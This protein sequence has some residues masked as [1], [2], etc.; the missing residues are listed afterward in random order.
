ME[1][2]SRKH[3]LLTRGLECV[4][5]DGETVQ[6]TK[7]GAISEWGNEFES[8]ACSGPPEGRACCELGLA[9]RKVKP[10]NRLEALDMMDAYFNCRCACAAFAAAAACVALSVLVSCLTPVVALFAANVSRSE[11]GAAPDSAVVEL[12][13]YA[14]FA[15]FAA[16]LGTVSM[17]AVEV[18]ENIF[19]TQAHFAFTRGAGRQY[20]LPWAGDGSPWM[21]GFI[22]D[23]STARPW[24]AASSA[25]GDGGH[26][27]SL[28]FR[29]WI[30]AYASGAS[31]VIAE[32]G[33][34]NLFF[35]NVSASDGVL[36]LSP[37]GQAAQNFSAFVAGQTE[38][39][40][41]YVPFALVMEHAHVSRSKHCRPASLARGAFGSLTSSSRTTS[42]KRG[43]VAGL[44]P[45]HGWVHAKPCILG[46]LSALTVGGGWLDTSGRALAD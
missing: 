20:G 25:G 27:V 7:I 5:P 30:T 12:T 46:T 9:N 33:G 31:Q 13:G 23:Y 11:A 16:R 36:N 28:S 44:W 18:M 4:N 39:A 1:A 14:L 42:H 3:G 43:G 22:T 45:Q 35:E 17:V 37:M 10:A 38:R 19:G 34:V 26:S 41:P 40:T 32:A 24:G 21:G 8:F 2:A 6:G 15:A 29:I